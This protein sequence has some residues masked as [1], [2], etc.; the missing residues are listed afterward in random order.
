[1]RSV[2]W[3]IIAAGLVLGLA[4]VG[5][6][7][8]LPEDAESRGAIRVGTSD[9]VSSLDPAGAYDAGS[10]ALY[11]NIYQS[12][13]T[14]KP[15]SD[16]PVPDAAASCGFVGQKL[17]T[18]QCE[19][20]PDV[21]FGGGR[22]ITAE[23]VKHSFDRIKAINSEQGPAPLFNTLESVGA[24]GRTVTFHLSAGDA[25]FPFKIAT[26][27]A[28]IVD[29]DTY[30]ATSLREDGR[31]DGSGPYTLASY[32]AGARAELKPNVSYKGQGKPARTAVTVRYFKGSEQ[33]AQAWTTRQIEVAHR[34]MPPAVL[35]GLNPGLQDT[36]Y[37][38]SGGSETRSIVFNVRPGSAA[39]PLAVRQAVA[40]VLDR[41]KLAG[42]VHRGTVTPLYSL[43]PA[44][45]AGHSTPFFD[46][47]PT[48]DGATAKKLLKEAG[49]HGPV[50]LRLGVNVRG[51]NLPE[52]EEIKRQ[53]EATGLFQVTLKPVEA[54]KDFQKAYAAGEFDAYTIGW[55]ADFPDADNFLAPL[56]GADSSMNNG[57]SDKRVDELITRTQSHSERSDA[58][59]EFRDLQKAVAQQAPMVPIWQKKDY[60]MSREAVTG[61]QN[62]SDGTGVWRLR[63]LNWI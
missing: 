30:P 42:E 32:E 60:V 51:A 62:L 15:G 52:A 29:K 45:I 47:Y 20:R 7:Q 6:W 9:V 31:V 49:T 24:E 21:T 53:L 61:A 22:A 46:T 36:R 4:G 8:L 44:G 23:D 12:L 26:G 38:A 40:A 19:L 63:E 13:L 34:D 18:Y 58:A 37:Q 11:S 33:L 43:V 50:Q 25:T 1:M 3:K 48:P 56:V 59:A 27:A 2:R 57:F 16:A 54:W 35:A 55:I 10:W 17:T 39:A 41:A 28:S 14:M 5:A